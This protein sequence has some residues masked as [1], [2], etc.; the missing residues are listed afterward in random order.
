MNES[1]GKIKSML[2]QKYPQLLSDITYYKA[3]FSSLENNS[4]F[5]AMQQ[6]FLKSVFADIINIL[7][8]LQVKIITSASNITNY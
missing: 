3:F 6:N 4:G 2:C 5:H 1:L 8:F 7:P